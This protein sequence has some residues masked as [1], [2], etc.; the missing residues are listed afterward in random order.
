LKVTG[1]TNISS[2]HLSSA[3][4]ALIHNAQGHIIERVNGVKYSLGDLDQ[5]RLVRGSQSVIMFENGNSRA[6]YDE[7]QSAPE[8]PYLPGWSP[9]MYNRSEQDLIADVKIAVEAANEPFTP[10]SARRFE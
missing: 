7:Y 1:E 10:W 9:V 6:P 4:P 8:K 5:Y 3:R 2:I